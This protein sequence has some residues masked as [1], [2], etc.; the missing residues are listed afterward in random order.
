MSSRSILNIPVI[1]SSLVSELLAFAVS[2]ALAQKSLKSSCRKLGRW[3]SKSWSAALEIC[4]EWEFSAE[5][6]TEKRLW[7][8]PL[9]A[10]CV[11][12]ASMAGC[13][14]SGFVCVADV[15]LC[16]S[17]LL[18]ANGSKFELPK[19]ELGLKENALS[20]K[21]AVYELSIRVSSFRITSGT[22]ESKLNNLSRMSWSSLGRVEV[23]IFIKS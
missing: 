2:E 8:L 18:V 22:S 20:A 13:L 11:V 9:F 23:M 5:V 12:V 15:A 10:R 4:G 19:W 16:G 6:R 7:S 14:E 1:C 21:E 3:A 17:P